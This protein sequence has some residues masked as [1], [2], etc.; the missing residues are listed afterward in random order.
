[1]HVNHKEALMKSG[2]RALALL[3]AVLVLGVAPAAQAE[4]DYSMN[5]AGG[6]YA[7]AATTQADTPAA[8]TDSEFAWGAAALGAGAA[9]AVVLL[10]TVTLARVGTARSRREAA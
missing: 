4:V 7:P 6:D 10:V 3:I 2:R 1:L 9:L 8:S 5:A